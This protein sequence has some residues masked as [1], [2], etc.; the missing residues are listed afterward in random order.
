MCDYWLP[1]SCSGNG[2]NTSTPQRCDYRLPAAPAPK[3]KRERALIVF[4][5]ITCT[6]NSSGTARTRDHWFPLAPA[7]KEIPFGT[8]L[9]PSASPDFRNGNKFFYGLNID[10]TLSPAAEINLLP[11]C[12]NL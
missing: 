1:P 6:E 9:G 3:Q 2:K 4:Q 11:K 8:N 12:E 5:P 10:F 7:L